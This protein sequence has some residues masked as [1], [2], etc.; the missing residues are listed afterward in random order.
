MTETKS[1]IAYIVY[2]GKRGMEAFIHRE[3]TA[4]TSRGIDIE[5]FF[6]QYRHDP[7]YG[8]QKYGRK[9]H[10]L[11]IINIFTAVTR[12][13]RACVKNRNLA[14]FA[15][16]NGVVLEFA[17]ACYYASIMR[18]RNI[19]HIHC[20]FGD[21]KLTVGFFCAELLNLSLS[22]TIHAHEIH[23]S[24]NPYVFK[25]ALKRCCRIFAISDYTRNKLVEKFNAPEDTV[26]TSRLFVDWKKFENNRSTITVLTVGRFVERKGHKY[27]LEAAGLLRDENIRFIIIGFGSLDIRQMV[28]D[29]D[30]EDSVIVFDKMSQKELQFFYS[31]V[32][33]FCLPSVDHPEE[34]PEG[35]P[36]VL[37]EAMA[38]GMP[39]ITTATGGTG[40]L[41]SEIIVPQ[42]DPKAIAENIMYLA[43]NPDV[44]RQMGQENQKIVRNQYSPENLNVLYDMFKGLYKPIKVY[45]AGGKIE[46]DHEEKAGREYFY[47][48]K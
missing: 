48:Y 2:G 29:Y 39:V 7:I 3:I 36:V 45:R 6:T 14:K 31:N 40:E 21:R 28:A 15:I 44:R 42:Q 11:K 24:P 38:A 25:C 32:D 4:L 23:I 17:L 30:L 12:T 34:G 43:K 35:I 10:S 18:C 27:L 19:S 22:V 8:P 37:M 41:V 26:I 46:G 33:I 1:R 5:L 16:T 9:W 20:H 13:L 47:S